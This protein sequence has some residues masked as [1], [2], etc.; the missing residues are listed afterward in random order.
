LFSAVNCSCS[1]SSSDNQSESSDVEKTHKVTHYDLTPPVISQV[2]DLIDQLKDVPQNARRQNE[3]V[4][5]SISY[6][7]SGNVAIVCYRSGICLVKDTR[8]V[9]IQSGINEIEFDNI[10][11]GPICESINFR[12][13]KKGRITVLSY[14][15]D[16]NDI[17]REHLLSSA[18]G[19][20]V[21]YLVKDDTKMSKGKLIGISKEKDANYAVISNGDKCFMIPTKECVAID[22]N[23]LKN[24]RKN[25][26][27][28]ICQAEEQDDMD[29]QISY[30]T[31]ILSWKHFCCI[32]VF[33]NLDRADIYSLAFVKNNSDQ[34]LKNIDVIF[35]TSSP[36]METSIPAT[37]YLQ[38][39]NQNTLSYQR[40]LSIDKRSQT[41]CVLRSAKSIK[42]TLEYIVKI[43]LSAIDNSL[44]KEI[45]LPVNNMLIINTKAA[46]IGTSFHDS[47]ALIFCRNN[48]ERN[49][50]GRQI[51]SS[52]KKDDDL[53]FEIGNAPDIVASVQQTD[54]KK[55][56][57]KNV[58]YGVRVII[59]NNKLTDSVT[60]VMVDTQFPWNVIKRNF[61]LQKSEKP[62][63]RLELQPNESKEL[64]FRMRVTLNK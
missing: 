64:H 41:M 33:Q 24:I 19:E 3:A 62:V 23:V 57:E 8:N 52:I 55:I 48:G 56:S 4:S 10:F 5:S 20:D 45:E 36:S 50:L 39:E 26:L 38:V 47:D 22:D 61:E 40:N 44:S 46:E 34:D 63:W 53:V 31:N 2:T 42:P 32:E 9:K 12:T 27:K 49:F 17:S 11:P 14:S 16:K 28:L 1:E 21:F 30:L 37:Q 29:I 43:P 35:D 60:L 58:E 25:S 7:N 51:L 15:I 59:K 13:P 54:F 18:V 6:K